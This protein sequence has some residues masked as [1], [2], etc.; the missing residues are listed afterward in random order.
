MFKHTLPQVASYA[1]VKG[2]APAGHD[3]SEVATLVHHKTLNPKQGEDNGCRARRK[4]NAGPSTAQP[5][6]YAACSAQDDNA[7]GMRRK[8]ED[9]A[10]RQAFLCV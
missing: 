2:Q 1:D 8:R 10:I 3:V 5:A 6:K 7:I 4:A 9:Q